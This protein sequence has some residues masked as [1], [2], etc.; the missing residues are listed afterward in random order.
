MRC[1]AEQLDY[2]YRAA[3]LLTPQE[4]EA[5][6]RSVRSRLAGEQATPKQVRQ[7]CVFILEARHGVAIGWHV[8]EMQPA[9]QKG[10][11]L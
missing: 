9:K 5:F 6:M 8:L 10:R 11:P 2:V 4:R 7:A 3:A 1:D